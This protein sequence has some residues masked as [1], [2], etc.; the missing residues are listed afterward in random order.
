MTRTARALT[1]CLAVAVLVTGCVTVPSGPSVTVLPGTG[2]PF[3]QFQADDAS[4]RQFAA[5][6]SGVSTNQA[7]ADNVVAGAGI[8]TLLGAA[9]G[10][11]IGAIAGSPATGAAVGAG[12]GLLG[13]SAVGA[14]NAQTAQ[15]SVQRRYDAAYLQC[16][17]A[18]GHQVPVAR[19]SQRPYTQSSAVT[20]PAGSPPPPPPPPAGKAPSPP[21]APAAVAPP[22][23]PGGT[24]PPPPPT[25]TR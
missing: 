9:A 24:P 6:Q 25:W 17:Y 13:G 21:P 19:G 4:C 23:P 2:R 16:M 3:D 10:A 1:G 5:Q 7:G 14:G 22:P 12:F 15:V 18:K 20:P 11:A 8:G